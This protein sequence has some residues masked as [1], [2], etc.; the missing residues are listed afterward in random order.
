MP[1]YEFR[2]D[3]CECRFEAL[4]EAGA[5]SVECRV[6]GASATNRVYSAQAPSPAL[7]K[8]PGERRKQE[9]RNAELRKRTKAAFVA[10]RRARRADGRGT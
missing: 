6:C 5:G 10:G 9:R 4:V 3:A 7:V 1:L 8:S 2:C